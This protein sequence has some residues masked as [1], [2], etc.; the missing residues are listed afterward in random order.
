MLLVFAAILSATFLYNLFQRRKSASLPPGP[1]GLP[2]IGNIMNLPRNTQ[3]EYQHWLGF[4]D[5]Y[6]PISSITILGTTLIIIHDKEAAH[7]L[8]GKQSVRTSS[9]PTLHFAG[10]LCGFGKFFTFMSHNKT[11]QHHRKLVHQQLGSKSAISRWR[12]IQDIESRRL[13]S[14]ILGEPSN[15][16]EHIKTYVNIL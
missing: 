13:L 6:G 9:R 16:M 7:D 4:K 14:R 5:S 2:F 3:L 11:F 10:E 15:L 8:L 12:D 1:R